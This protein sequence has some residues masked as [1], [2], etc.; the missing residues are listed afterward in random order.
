MNTFF[1]LREGIP[2]ILFYNR[3]ICEYLLIYLFNNITLKR[4]KIF[5]VKDVPFFKP[6][7]IDNDVRMIQ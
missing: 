2:Q 3:I 1:F 5:T 4:V 7:G 6:S